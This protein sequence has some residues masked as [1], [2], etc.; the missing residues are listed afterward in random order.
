MMDDGYELYPIYSSLI[1]VIQLYPISRQSHISPWPPKS[2]DST[3]AVWQS[4][5]CPWQAA[6]LK[7]RFSDW[8]RINIFGPKKTPNK[9]GTA[10]DSYGFM[11]PSIISCW[12]KHKK[13]GRL[14]IGVRALKDTVLADQITLKTC[15][16]NGNQ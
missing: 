3:D 5:R 10:G 4:C 14:C 15:A 8:L 6:S 9:E 12:G 1:M 2:A 16:T 7:V 13:H 11:L